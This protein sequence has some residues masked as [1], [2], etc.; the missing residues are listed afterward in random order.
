M[1]F[2]AFRDYVDLK[3]MLNPPEQSIGRNGSTCGENDVTRYRIN[4]D[5]GLISASTFFVMSRSCMF[6][7]IPSSLVFNISWILLGILDTGQTSK[8]YRVKLQT[9]ISRNGDTKIGKYLL[10]KKI[11][12]K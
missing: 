9:G 2:N 5:T 12:Q 3:N 6:G 11:D 7:I 8:D 1:Y 4:L 10:S